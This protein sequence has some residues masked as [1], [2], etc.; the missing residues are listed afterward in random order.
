MKDMFGT[1]WVSVSISP[2][3]G[4]AMGGWVHHRTSSSGEIS[5]PFGVAT[6]GDPLAPKEPDNQER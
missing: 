2:L 5:D 4:D 1:D 6:A 3:Q